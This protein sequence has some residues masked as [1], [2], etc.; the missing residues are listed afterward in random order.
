MEG[1]T[2]GA[3]RQQSIAKLIPLTKSCEFGGCKPTPQHKKTKPPQAIA[4]HLVASVALLTYLG[5]ARI[6][7]CLWLGLQPTP[8]WYPREDEPKGVFRV[9]TVVY[10]TFYR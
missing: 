2:S 7:L 8:I 1:K 3:M 6:E 9:S 5:V 4:L 10:L